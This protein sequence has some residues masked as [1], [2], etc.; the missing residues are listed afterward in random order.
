MRMFKSQI[1]VVARIIFSEYIYLLDSFPYFYLF[2]IKL[3]FPSF[4]GS[5][6]A[7][8]KFSIITA[9]FPLFLFSISVSPLKK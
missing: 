4:T 3:N 7:F 8:E 6:K 9:R 1:P 2:R 5:F